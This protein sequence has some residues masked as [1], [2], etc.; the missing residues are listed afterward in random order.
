MDPMALRMLLQWKAQQVSF[1]GW[2]TG[3]DLDRLTESW[4]L[5]YRY[6]Q[7]DTHGSNGG[8][9]GNI[10][11]NI[12]YKWAIFHGYVQITRWYNVGLLQC[13]KPPILM[14]LMLG[15]PPSLKWWWMGDGANDI[16][17]YQHLTLFLNL[18]LLLQ[19]FLWVLLIDGWETPSSSKRLCIE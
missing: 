15:I 9:N 6:G 4:Q 2:I 8:F 7:L 10:Y 12:I 1:L 11:G 5:Y 16:A 19:R 14:I 18:H 17:I 13:H 3:S